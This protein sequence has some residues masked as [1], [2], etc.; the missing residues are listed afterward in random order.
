MRVY[1]QDSILIALTG[2]EFAVL[3]TEQ[4]HAAAAPHHNRRTRMSAPVPLTERLSSVALQHNSATLQFI[5]VYLSLVAGCCAGVLGLTGWSG[6]GFYAASTLLHTLFVLQRI[7]QSSLKSSKS[8]ALKSYFADWQTL[9]CQHVVQSGLVSFAHTTASGLQ[10]IDDLSDNRM[11]QV[12]VNP[13]P[14]VDCFESIRRRVVVQ[15][16]LA[17]SIDHASKARIAGASCHC[18]TR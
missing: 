17:R 6:L 2:P 7:Y 4:Q 12:T 18:I 10:T 13:L 14:P 9:A 1:L 3:S 5:R 16:P 8:D 15:T 11:R